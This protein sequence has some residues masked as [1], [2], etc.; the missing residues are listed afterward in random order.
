VLFPNERVG[1]DGE[2]NIKI[3]GLQRA[4]FKK[5]SV[6][7]RLQFKGHAEFAP[8]SKTVLLWRK[9]GLKQQAPMLRY[10]AS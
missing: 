4:E 7:V 9:T 10:G 5:F 6:Q 1:R 2:K 8:R 3:I